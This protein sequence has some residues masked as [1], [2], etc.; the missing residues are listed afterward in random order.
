MFGFA[1]FLDRANHLNSAEMQ[2]GVAQM[3]DTI[4][5]RGPDY[6]GSWVDSEDGIVLGFRKLA[7]L[8]LSPTRHQPM[9]S[10]NVL[11]FQAW[12]AEH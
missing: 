11:M 5:Q 6:L 3:S 2:A 8:D 9:V 1:G 10:W 12:L 4:T 7:I